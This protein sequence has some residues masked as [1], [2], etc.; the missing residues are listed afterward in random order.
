[1]AGVEE[2]ADSATTHAAF[3]VDKL[4]ITVQKT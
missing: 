1:M 2:D 3:V 4:D